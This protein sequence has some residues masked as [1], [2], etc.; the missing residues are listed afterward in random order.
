M[1]ETHRLLGHAKHLAFR[2]HIL[3]QGPELIVPN[4]KSYNL[5]CGFSGGSDGKAFACNVEDLGSVPGFGRSPEQGN[6]NLKNSMGRR[7]WKSD[8]IEQLTLS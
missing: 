5:Y 7:A 6:G 4:F 1:L 3:P 2:A 8:P